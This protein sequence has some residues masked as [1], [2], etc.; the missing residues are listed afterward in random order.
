MHSTSC[1]PDRQRT[2]PKHGRRLP[3]KGVDRTA[4]PTRWNL[5][6]WPGE[7][8][9]H[10]APVAG[11]KRW[12]QDGAAQLP[13]FGKSAR[14]SATPC[15]P[16][17]RRRDTRQDGTCQK[18]G[19][20]RRSRPAKL[21]RHSHPVQQVAAKTGQVDRKSRTVVRG[22]L[23]PHLIPDPAPPPWTVLSL[24]GSPPKHAARSVHCQAFPNRTAARV[25]LTARPRLSGIV[26]A[27]ATR[28][29]RRNAS[30]AASPDR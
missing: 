30:P 18:M 8:P 22:C 24:A 9:R 13:E 15:R 6:N 16:G 2:E 20:R 27:S 29:G 10:A 3:V 26:D 25:Q 28:A 11:S 1:E 17:R 23:Q 21:P 19:D 12:R 4:P 14:R 7:V 5:A